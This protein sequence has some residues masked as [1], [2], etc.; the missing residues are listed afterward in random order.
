MKIIKISFSTTCLEYEKNT[1]SAGARTHDLQ[2]EGLR[3]YQ[4]D[5][6]GDRQ[7]CII[8]NWIHAAKWSTHTSR[9]HQIHTYIDGW[10]EHTFV[11]YFFVRIL[12][13]PGW[14]ERWGLF[15]TFLHFLSVPPTPAV[16]APAIVFRHE[17]GPAVPF[18][19]CWRWRSR[20]CH[21]SCRVCVFSR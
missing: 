1:Q 6:R 16:L 9:C 15:F 20:I 18:R 8:V 12:N 5:R 11:A 3:W 19:F 7:K 14:G 21:N 4:I 13:Q 10:E 17:K 2:L